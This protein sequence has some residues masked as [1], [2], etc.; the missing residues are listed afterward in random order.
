M[1]TNVL[2]AELAKQVVGALRVPISDLVTTPVTP[3]VIEYLSRVHKAASVPLRRNYGLY[4]TRAAA[5]FGGHQ[6]DHVQPSDIQVLAQAASEHARRNTATRTGRGAS[7]TCLRA[8]R[9]FFRLAVADGW[10]AED[11]NPAAAASLPRRVP[12][13]RFALTN[14]ELADLNEVV[15]T[16]GNDIGLD[17]LIHRLHVETACRRGGVLA[18]RVRDLD[19]ATCLV[20][21]RE[22]RG[23]QRWQPVSPYLMQALH[24]HSAARGADH[25]EDALL[26]YADGHPLTGRRY[27]TLWNRIREA[28]PW[29]DARAVSA[30]WLRHTTLTW[31]E[32]NFGYAVARAYAGHTD[33]HGGST[34]TYIKADVFA[35]AEALSVLTSE[36]HPL[37]QASN[38]AMLPCGVRA[39]RSWL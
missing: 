6:L 25:P 8:M 19:I 4:W 26:R 1:T 34:T 5:A 12:S 37:T 39:F 28:L 2:R 10:V 32:R 35:V 18:L 31:V 15:A 22:K 7:E 24:D 16:G 14:H 13:P 29:A 3:T 11:R 27:D 23:T 21:L 33:R 38:G 36:P 17:C 9:R 20:R 30:H